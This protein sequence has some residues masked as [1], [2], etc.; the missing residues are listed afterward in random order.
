MHDLALHMC[1]AAMSIKHFNYLACCRTLYP[2]GYNN[3]N[4]ITYLS[5]SRSS[6]SINGI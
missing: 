1:I 5:N 2:K 3:E 4:S 6:T